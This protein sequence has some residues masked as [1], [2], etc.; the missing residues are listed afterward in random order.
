MQFILFENVLYLNSLFLHAWHLFFIIF[1]HGS[2]LWVIFINQRQA[3]I[4][5]S[6][7]KPR[8]NTMSRRHSR[9]RRSSMTRGSLATV[10]STSRSSHTWSHAPL[11]T[12]SSREA[13]AW[14]RSRAVAP[15]CPSFSRGLM[16]VANVDDSRVVLDTASDDNAITSSSSSSTWS[17]TCHVSRYWPDMN[18][19]ALGRWTL[20]MLCE[21]PRT[22]RMWWSSTSGGA[23]ARGTTSLMSPG[24]TSFGSP[25]KSHRY[26]SCRARSMTTISRIVAS[27]WRRRRHRGGSTTVTSSSSS[28]PLG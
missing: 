18:S 22:W 1:F 26:S 7:L 11:C 19:C 8:T 24:C 23:T 28:P 13:A 12:T 6:Y 9:W 4:Y 15:R 5:V 25:T 10:S 27:S 20:L 14:M 16:V 17:P 21:C 2:D 3:W